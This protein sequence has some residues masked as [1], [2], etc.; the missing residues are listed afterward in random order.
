[1]KLLESLSH[2]T[3][4]KMGGATRLLVN[5]PSMEV[6]N[7]LDFIKYELADFRILSIFGLALRPQGGSVVQLGILVPVPLVPLM[8]LEAVLEYL[9]I[10][11]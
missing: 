8:S 10:P 2:N 7:L 4:V 5:C 11:L 6:S 9:L 1:M 3:S